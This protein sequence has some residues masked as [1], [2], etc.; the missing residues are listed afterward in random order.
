MIGPW[1]PTL[2]PRR[3]RAERRRLRLAGKLIMD[4]LARQFIAKL[5]AHGHRPY[6]DR[7]VFGFQPCVVEPTEPPEPHPIAG[8]SYI[9]GFDIEPFAAVLGDRSRHG[10][11]VVAV[12]EAEAFSAHVAGIDR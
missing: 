12:R 7:G 9:F 2:E 4:D 8:R 5:R 10:E 11:L 1:P 3:T 6:V